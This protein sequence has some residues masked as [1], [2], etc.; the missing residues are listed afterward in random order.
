MNM[1][2]VAGLIGRNSDIA[3]GV[4]GDSFALVL[5]VSGAVSLG[6]AGYHLYKAPR[7]QPVR[8]IRSR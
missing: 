7:F 4:L 6:I 8:V 1:L 2:I 5:F 3:G